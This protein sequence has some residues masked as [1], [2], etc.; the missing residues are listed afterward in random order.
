MAAPKRP[1]ATRPLLALPPWVPGESTLAAALV[2]LMTLAIALIALNG[3]MPRFQSDDDRQTLTALP[4][5]QMEPAAT[6]AVAVAMDDSAAPLAASAA[7]AEVA[8]DV[9]SAAPLTADTA[10]GMVAVGA[11]LAEAAVAGPSAFVPAPAPASASQPESV[12]GAIL[13]GN[14]VLAYYGHPHDE[15]M[16]IVGEYPKEEVLRL[17]LQQAADYEVVDPTRPVIPAFEL[18]ATVAQRTPGDD[19]SYILD[20]DLETLTEYADFAQAN[21]ALVFLDL[22][23][24]RGTVAAEIEKIRPLLERPHVHLALDPEFAVGEG[25]TPGEYIGSLDA[26]SIAYAQRTLAQ[27]V[28]DFGLPPKLLIVHQFR[29]DMI[30]NKLSLR[31]VA[32]VQLVIDADGYG[33]PELKVAVYNILVR[34]EPVEFAGVKLFYKQDVPVMTPAEILGLT[35]APDVVIYQ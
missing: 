17:L 8:A 29:E 26:E 30:A 27:M 28:S 14:R 21:G 3:A 6:S 22:Q 34:D 20:T 18:I 24:G 2:L 35:P 12:P 1:P 15:N 9:G 5:G 31:P 4:G 19:G 16:G 11:A 10:P 7:P 23:I 25:E 33:A 32:G 13:P